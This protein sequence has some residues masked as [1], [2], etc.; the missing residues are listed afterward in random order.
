MNPRLH[1]NKTRG[2]SHGAD[3]RS[4]RPDFWVPFQTG[5]SARSVR[6]SGG[7]G[8]ELALGSG[9]SH[10]KPGEL[11]IGFLLCTWAPTLGSLQRASLAGP[12]LQVLKPRRG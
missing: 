2:D 11:G 3:L 10:L 1:F 4:N 9:P 6:G 12:D 7:L 8:P 5:G